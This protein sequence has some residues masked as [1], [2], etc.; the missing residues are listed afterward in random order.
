MES[1]PSGKENDKTL[2]E[3][4]KEKKEEKVDRLP[5][6]V[7]NVSPRLMILSFVGLEKPEP[8][9]KVEKLEK[10]EQ[11]KERKEKAKEKA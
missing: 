5:A 3:K 8:P 1:T 6:G 2:K 4:A 9:I 11:E 10:E 7:T